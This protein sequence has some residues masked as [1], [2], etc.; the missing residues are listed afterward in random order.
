MSDH[1]LLRTLVESQVE[2]DIIGWNE[3]MA[4]I[5]PRR[6]G[7]LPGLANTWFSYI[8]YPTI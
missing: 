7:I 8:F 5:L 2:I 4:N 1:E 3:I 6:E